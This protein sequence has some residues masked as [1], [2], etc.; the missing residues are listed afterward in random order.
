MLNE[1]RVILMTRM[2]SYESDEGKKNMDIGK[3]FRGDYI[4]MQV[5]KSIISATVSFVICFAL[6]LLYDF[7]NFMENIYAMDLV[8]FAK[9]IVVIY[10]VVTVG[11]AL[12]TY[13][14]FS[15]RYKKA[16]KS[17]KKYYNNLRKLSGLYE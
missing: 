5:L 16:R 6:Y 14:V 15:Y 9:D 3:Y 8:Q 17:L 7:E 10:V 13:I 12:I 2:A 1:E 4:G 11:Y